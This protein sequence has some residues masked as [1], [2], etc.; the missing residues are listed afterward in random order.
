MASWS[1]CSKDLESVGVAMDS[2]G[3]R[4]CVAPA[5]LGRRTAT[6]A[7]SVSVFRVRL[8]VIC[9]FNPD[10]RDKPINITTNF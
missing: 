5:P 7:D 4:E 2:A 10:S 9:Y 3:L 6:P 1:T 8:E